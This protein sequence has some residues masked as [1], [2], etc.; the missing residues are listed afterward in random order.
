MEKSNQRCWFLARGQNLYQILVS[1]LNAPSFF[2]CLQYLIHSDVSSFDLNLKC[3]LIL[4]LYL[5]DAIPWPVYRFSTSDFS[6]WICHAL[7]QWGRLLQ[8]RLQFQ[9]A[10]LT[11]P[12]LIKA[13][14]MPKVKKSS[15]RCWFFDL[16]RRLLQEKRRHWQRV[17]IFHYDPRRIIR[18][19]CPERVFALGFLI[20]ILDLWEKFEV[21]VRA[22]A[23][24]IRCSLHI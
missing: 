12:T 19:F 11:R 13:Y 6:T 21:F 20:F 15:Q 23:I 16:S 17:E 5:Q 9:F 2:M 8:V 14:T 4:I 7:P 1:H 24:F 10:C 22:V 18:F 3:K